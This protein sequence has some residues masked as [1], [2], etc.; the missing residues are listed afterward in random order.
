MRKGSKRSTRRTRRTRRTRK[1][2]RSKKSV[3]RYSKK[4]SRKSKR[5]LLSKKRKQRGGMMD[6]AGGDGGVGSTVQTSADAA[7]R[8]FGQWFEGLTG[9]GPLQAELDKI[10]GE[11]QSKE[12]ECMGLE[13][14]LTE[15]GNTL[16]IRA[17]EIE[18]ERKI[19]RSQALIIT[20]QTR[21]LDAKDAKLKEIG[22]KLVEY[23]E[24]ASAAAGT[25]GDAGGPLSLPVD[26]KPSSPEPGSATANITRWQTQ[27]SW[28][29][30]AWHTF[31]K[32]TGPYPRSTIT[33]DTGP[34]SGGQAP[35]GPHNFTINKHN[36]EEGVA[37][38]QLDPFSI[39]DLELV[40]INPITKTLTLRKKNKPMRG[41]HTF[42]ISFP[43]DAGGAAAGAPPSASLQHRSTITQG[44]KVE[45]GDA[46]IHAQQTIM[47]MKRYLEKD[48]ENGAPEVGCIFKLHGEGPGE[49]EEIAF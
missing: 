7:P 44:G 20:E 43:P 17:A 49:I 5:V 33:I 45:A 1:G 38:K 9:V 2:A 14:R 39:I 46:F 27:M 4:R 15:C 10:K 48:R 11:V 12:E 16:L 28:M 22:D 24:A 19:G 26:P 6:A 32:D 30:K 41:H 21:G 29:S 34:S 47:N 18:A 3:R 13:R 25:R 31:G 37:D 36:E 42:E 35:S 23:K 40:E 8:G